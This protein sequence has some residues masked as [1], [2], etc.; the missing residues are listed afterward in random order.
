[1]A[2]EPVRGRQRRLSWPPR[3]EM[4]S[5]GAPTKSG[6]SRAR[7]HQRSPAWAPGRLQS[8][9]CW[10]RR[11]GRRRLGLLEKKKDY[12][13]RADD[14][15]RKEKALQVRALLCRRQVQPSPGLSRPPLLPQ[16]LQRKA[17]ERNPDEFH[18]AMQHAQTKQG[19]HSLACV[20]ACPICFAAV[21]HRTPTDARRRAA[22]ANKYSREELLLM[23]SQDASYLALKASVEAKAGLL[24]LP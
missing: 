23:K 8:S 19:V 16:V 2:P 10:A 1:M 12:K 15:H 18:F 21:L 4:L 13:R 6:P 17:E 3:C 9:P 5:S 20:P 24:R 22:E 11:A 7:A 14:F